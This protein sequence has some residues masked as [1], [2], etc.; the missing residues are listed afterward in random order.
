[1]SQSSSALCVPS[2]TVIRLQVRSCFDS[3]RQTVRVTQL[4]HKLIPCHKTHDYDTCFYERTSFF[5]LL[6]ETFTWFHHNRK[7]NSNLIDWFYVKITLSSHVILWDSLHIMYVFLF[8][9]FSRMSLLFN[10]RI[11]VIYRF[12]SDLLL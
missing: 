3:C 8:F 11:V 5:Y 10:K 2:L 12:T 1:M 9:S 6:H 7:N 4:S